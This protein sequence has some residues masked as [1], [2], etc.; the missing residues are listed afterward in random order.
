MI[1]HFQFVS[2]LIAHFMMVFIPLSA[3]ENPVLVEEFIFDKAPF[4]SCH[5]STIAES[6][7][8]LVAAFFG[9]THEKNEDVEIWLSTKMNRAWS[10]PYS[11]A[12]GIFDG[13]RYPCWN[14]VLYQVPGG[15][16]ILFYKV[17]TDPESW[18]G[19][20]KRSGDGGQTWSLAEKLPEGN[21][22]PV[23]NKPVLLKNGNLLCPSSTEDN[24]WKVH[25]EITGDFGKSWKPNV[26]VDPASE[27][28]VIQP[29]ILQ[30]ENG[31]LQILCRSQNGLIIHSISVDQGN[32][33]SVLEPV[34]L[35]NPNSGI[36]AI[37]LSNGI[38]LLAYN[39]SPKPEK[40][41]GGPRYPLNI[42]ISED[43]FS[44]KASVVLEEKP[45]EYSYPAVIQDQKGMVHVIY[46]WNREKIKHVVL[47]PEKLPSQSITIWN[48]E[49]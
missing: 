21:L 26:A 3:Q 47:D 30:H 48:R 22:G 43:G 18:W 14:P 4:K 33:W 23:K 1:Y 7:D 44:W 19:M 24:G 46:T 11:V 16:L 40:E 38:H 36:D 29:T 13:K 49:R 20:I 10:A 2:L 12:D 6:G 5:A 34:G 28:Q 27:Y 45:G 25:M 17:G 32:S 37:T 15:E 42:A 41:W 31:W 39:H 35:P 8:K 9:G